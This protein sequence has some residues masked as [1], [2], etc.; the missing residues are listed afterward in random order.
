MKTTQHTVGQTIREAAGHVL[1]TFA[2]AGIFGGLAAGLAYV[3]G[4]ADP[5]TAAG[6]FAS[7]VIGLDLLHVLSH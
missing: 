5:L 6:V 1:G 2:V 4:T 3:S 7:A